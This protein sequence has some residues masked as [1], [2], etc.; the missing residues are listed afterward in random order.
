MLGGT[1]FDELNAKEKINVR[2]TRKYMEGVIEAIHYMHDKSIAHRDIKPENILVANYG[3]A[4]ICD[5]GW[6]AVMTTSRKTYCGT[7]DYVAPEIL[8]RKD[9]GLS[10]DIWCLGILVYELLSGKMPYE[11]DKRT[12]ICKKITNVKILLCA[13]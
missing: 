6:S 3:V 12:I 7:F 2:E 5:M 8:E 10:V 4:K 13:G 1:L 11:G 9:Y